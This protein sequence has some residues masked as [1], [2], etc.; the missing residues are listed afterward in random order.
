M[1][2]PEDGSDELIESLL[3]EERPNENAADGMGQLPRAALVDF[4]Q[5]NEPR[6][7]DDVLTI[8]S[9]LDLP[10]PSEDTGTEKD[11]DPIELGQARLGVFS[12]FP[13]IDTR[14]PM[15]AVD[16]GIVELGNT[17]TGFAVAMKASAVMQS[18]TGAL[19]VQAF[20]PFIKMVTPSN[21]DG[22][23]QTI[24][25]QLGQPF[26]FVDEHGRAKESSLEPN[27]FR[28]RIRNFVERM[29]QLDALARLSNGILIVDGALQNSTF[30]T[31]LAFT[32]RLAKLATA[33]N[34]DLV[35][36][37]KESRV[38]VNNQTIISL[39]DDRVEAGY[40]R[41]YRIDS[42][43]GEAPELY[44]MGPVFACRFVPG[45]FT[46]RVDIA[47][48]SLLPGN[49]SVLHTFVA[50]ARMH[51]GYPNL[52]RLAHIHSAF[53]KQEVVALQVRL[54]RR[55]GLTLLPKR[56]VGVIFAPFK[57]GLGG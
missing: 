27:K 18:A 2:N 12:E 14:L 39:L 47:H 50:N 35:G 38:T 6:Q 1:A 24:G 32:N 49:E 51:L 36:I 46:W 42:A 10:M 45:G 11:S 9:D 40:R 37:S 52:L 44:M 22:I 16:S 15:V 41:I 21:R 17:R 43:G 31:P 5:T 3:R 7:V 8:T 25:R 26:L 29:C 20:G 19:T 30:N 28:D 33:Q 34:C 13:E 48:R 4:L 56:D 57:K 23:L 53:T 54:A 55:Y